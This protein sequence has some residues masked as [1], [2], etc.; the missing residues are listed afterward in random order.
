MRDLGR[1]LPEHV[2]QVTFLEHHE[3][4]VDM[5]R[6]E[7]L[8]IELF[9]APDVAPLDPEKL[10]A[11]PGEAWERAQ[12]SLNPA[13]ALLE[14]RFPVAELRTK[15]REATEPVP[16]PDPARQQLVL[17]RRERNL[18]HLAVDAA[19]FALL[20]ELRQGTP[21]VTACERTVAQSGDVGSLEENL[22][23]W[24]RQWGELGWIV[25]VTV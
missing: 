6:L 10:A 12:I 9:D 20:G 23:T 16:I 17:Y 25:D 1:Y 19:A 4:C 24:F 21:L 15:L 18:Y 22:F 14:V 5:A 8:Y 2:E 13:L 7:W 11:I 3:L